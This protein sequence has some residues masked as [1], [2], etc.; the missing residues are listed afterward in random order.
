MDGKSLTLQMNSLNESLER[1]FCELEYRGFLN[2]NT[3]EK[4]P[5]AD[6]LNCI[7]ANTVTAAISVPHFY[8]A[9]VDGI[10]VLSSS[11]FSATATTPLTLKIGEDAQFI[12]TGMPILPGFDAVVPIEDVKLKSIEGVEITG[13]YAPWENVR[14]LGEEMAAQEVILPANHRIR[15]FDIAAL[16]AGG[17]SHIDVVRKTRIGILPVG[18]A[19]VPTG[20]IP[21]V[22]QAMETSSQILSNTVLQWGAHPIL[23]DIVDENLVELSKKVDMIKSDVDLLCII[24]GPSLGTALIADM[25]NR[26][27]ELIC[28][29]LQIKPGMSTCLGIIDDCPIIGLPG[30]AMSAYIAFNHFAKPVIYKKLGINAPDKKIFKAYLSRTVRSPEDVDEF[31]RASLGYVDNMPVAVPI[32]RGAN[33]LMSLV[34]ADGIIH[35]S[36]KKSKIQAGELVNVELL[37]PRNDLKNKVFMAGSYDICFDIL[38]NEILRQNPDIILYN[39]NVGSM[40]GLIALKAGFCHLSG[41]HFFDDETGEFNIPIVKMFLD[42]MPLI[43]VNL[44]HRQLGFLVNKGNPKNILNFEDLTRPDVK[45]TNRIRGSGTRMILDYY[46]KKNKI[47]INRIKGYP[48]EAHTHLTLASAIASGHADVGLGISA[49]A[50]ASNLDFIPLIPERMDFVIPKKYLNTYSIKSLLSII[51][52]EKFKKEISMLDGYSTEMTGNIVYE[53]G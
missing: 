1:W 26:K 50:K 17:H 3:I 42:D 13:S 4:I 44:L 7:S 2:R 8:S 5:I 48:D 18:S 46:L 38:R 6:S 25:L 47:E 19:L 37:R 20:S 30:Y 12:D 40:R 51:G 35:I 11:T 41:I 27:G 34:R 31:I 53:I 24:G 9:S 49:A 36:N 28:Y 14:P 10:A 33:I 43:L 15:S 52:S 32:S 23:V 16:F 21:A 45:L 39:S 29:G 22:G